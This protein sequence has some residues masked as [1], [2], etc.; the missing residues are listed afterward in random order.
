MSEDSLYHH[1]VKGQKWGVRRFQ[2][3]DGTLTAKGKK[4]YGVSDDFDGRILSKKTK[5][6]RIT[7]NKEDTTYGGQK[8]LS[9]NKADHK[10]WQKYIGDA[11]AERGYET[12]NVKYMPVK[13]LKIAKAE[14]VGEL[15]TK[16][17]MKDPKI[18]NQVIEDTKSAQR[19]L[20]YSS[21]NTDDLLSLNFAMQT[22][23]GQMFINRLLEL[24]YDGIEDAHGR[25]TSKDPVIV[26]NPEQNLQ[27]KSTT[28]YK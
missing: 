4:H 1:G 28:R 5:F 20:G 9:T 25:N 21:D 10:A 26:F 8:Y 16:E 14:K 11:Y 15:L 13:D 19:K 24:G 17:F 6:Y 18:A 27:K 2:N 3:V 7:N 22:K 12:Y 23:S